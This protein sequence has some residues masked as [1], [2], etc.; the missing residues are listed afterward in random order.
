[1]V[2]QDHRDRDPADAVQRRDVIRRTT[3]LAYPSIS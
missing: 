1:M 3:S 2:Q